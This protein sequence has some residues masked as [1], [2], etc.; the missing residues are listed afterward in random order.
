MAWVVSSI[1]G[2]SFLPAWCIQKAQTMRL[3]VVVV[4]A[5]AKEPIADG[6]GCGRGFGEWEWNW[7]TVGWQENWEAGNAQRKNQMTNDI[8]LRHPEGHAH[9]EEW[10][11]TWSLG[12][13]AT[14]PRSTHPSHFSDRN[15][16]CMQ[17]QNSKIP[18]QKSTHRRTSG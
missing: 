13:C 5:G 4:A 18:R 15:S 10:A 17:T 2:F 8:L 3:V 16:S 6:R 1:Y 11:W 7:K 12:L 14:H 9:V